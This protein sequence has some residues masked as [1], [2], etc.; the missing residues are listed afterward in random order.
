VLFR[1][2]FPDEWREFAK[3][4]ARQTLAQVFADTD[5]ELVRATNAAP[6]PERFFEMFEQRYF[7]LGDCWYDW[8][9]MWETE[10]DEFCWHEI[11]IDTFFFSSIGDIDPHYVQ[12]VFQVVGTLSGE[13]EYHAECRTKDCSLRPVYL[14]AANELHKVDRRMLSGLCRRE[15]TPLKHLSFALD[16]LNKDTGNI[17]FDYDDEMYGQTGCHWHAET[18]RALKRDYD[19]ASKRAD[20]V[21]GLNNWLCEDVRRIRDASSLWRR[22]AA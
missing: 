21:M 14:I 10:G 20:D 9:D 19:A 5:A 8:L 3:G 6:P 16:V 4:I 12:P 22:C 2:L 15:Q 11:P 13:F 18:V 1:E 17:W 7:P